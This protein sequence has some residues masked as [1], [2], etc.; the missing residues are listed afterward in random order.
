MNSQT[1]TRFWKCFD[2]LPGRIQVLA[3]KNFALWKLNPWHPSLQ[4]K[5]LKPRLWS[6]R[7]VLSHRALAAFDGTTYIWFWIGD[8]DEYMHLIASL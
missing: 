3:N 4:F 8:H 2:R 5:E 6:V 1:S 7:I